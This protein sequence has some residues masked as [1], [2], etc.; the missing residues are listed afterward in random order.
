MKPIRPFSLSAAA[1]LAITLLLSSTP[2][3]AERPLQQVLF[4]FEAGSAPWTTNVWGG[5]G[6]VVLSASQAPKFGAGALHS[7]LKEVARGGNTISPWLPADAAWRKVD[8]GAI[9]LWFRGDGTATKAVLRVQTGE[10]NQVSQ[11]YSFDLPMDS[12]EWCRFILPIAAFWNRHHVPMETQRIVRCYVGHTGNH[13]FEVDQITLEA[14]QRPVPLTAASKPSKS[15][16]IPELFQFGD[17]RY[18]LRLD[19][20]ALFPAP[21]TV[22]ANFQFPGVPTQ[23]ATDTLSENRPSGE[24][25][26]LAS[27]PPSGGNSTLALDIE[28][29]KDRQSTAWTFNATPNRPLPDPTRLSLLPAPKECRLGSGIFSLSAGLTIEAAGSDGQ[30]AARMLAEGLG[31]YRTEAQI[32]DLPKQ[33]RDL[34]SVSIGQGSE[35]APENLKRLAQLP[36]GA[37]L[38]DSGPKGAS[39]RAREPEGLRNGIL[40]LSQAAESHW[41]LTGKFAIP[42][43]HAVDWPNLPIRAVSLTL[44][45]A[46]WGHPN[47]PPADPDSFL[48]F[49]HETVVRTKLNFVVIIIEQAMRFDSHPEVAGPAA[50]SKQDVKR[51]FDTL[52]GWG[53]EPV[54]CMNSLGHMNWLCI[55]RRDLAEDGDVHQICTSHPEA[56]PI[57]RDLYQEIIDLVHPKYFHAG[58][59]E[60]RWKTE[61]LP[62]DQRCP[63]CAGKSKQAIFV[64]W[65]NMLHDFFGK[66]NIRMMMWGDMIL[67]GHNGGPPYNLAKTAGRLPKDM[68]IANWST[69]LSPDSTPWLLGHGFAQVI[70]S[71]SAGATLAEQPLLTGNMFGCW[72]KVPWLVEGTEPGSERNAYGAFLEAAEYSWNHWPDLFDPM[73]PLEAG[74]FED[75]P[76]AQMR[77]GADPVEGEPIEPVVLPGP[78]HL[79]GL[80]EGAVR[81][82]HLQFA[83]A[84]AVSPD[85]GKEIVVPVGRQATALY[86]LHAANLPD[87]AAMVEALKRRQHW[88]GVPVAE[89]EVRYASGKSE[90]IPVRYSME[91][92]DPEPDWC[93][94]PIAYNSLGVYPATAAASGVHLYSMQWKNP[95]PGDPIVSITLRPTASAPAQV[96]LAGM[97]LQGTTRQ[98]APE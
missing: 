9:S 79:P 61:S 93:V 95:H 14:P 75:R 58:L 16:V 50:W 5:P 3:Q 35:T 88:Q 2:A 97:A 4:D 90:I 32:T 18:G 15:A 8:W 11:D 59:D 83:V 56:A 23:T 40:T 27:P 37:Y 92:R 62:P 19:P 63:R 22:R 39:V 47:D 89:Y 1:L 84:G 31:K 80:P 49:L 7:V 54:P 34:I 43:L 41:A 77:I 65:V 81:F 48:R 6:T 94:A 66:Q 33:K 96:I 69:R 82:G 85:A 12:A 46:R 70:K 51:V 53:V 76:L 91:L 74:F 67:P 17:G 10:G 21:V 87:R 29:G 13:S 26:L 55:P 86:L 20:S 68:T 30:L 60:V 44:P 71:N 73:P 72:Y 25:L 36:A 38:L 28:H 24:S 78:Q 42:E 57:V 52:R 98:S 64:D 45:N